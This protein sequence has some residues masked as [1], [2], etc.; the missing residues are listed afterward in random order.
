MA[1]KTAVEKGRK[2]FGDAWFTLYR[3]FSSKEAAE[4]QAHSLKSES[5]T[6]ITSFVVSGKPF[7]RHTSWAL[8]ERRRPSG[9]RR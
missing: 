7:V 8:W 3:T 9:K 1:K 4:R 6:R 2:K 5:F